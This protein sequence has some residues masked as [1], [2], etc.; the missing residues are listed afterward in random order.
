MSDVRASIGGRLNSITTQ[1]SVRPASRSSCKQSISTLQSL[2]Y[3]SAITTLDSAKHDL[4][5]RPAG[6]SR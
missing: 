6:V 1:Q 3:A 5:R 4:E 2:D